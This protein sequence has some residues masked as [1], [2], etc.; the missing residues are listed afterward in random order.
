MN[1][2]LKATRP[3]SIDFSLLLLRL[4]AGLGMAFGHGLPKLQS[5][6]SKAD[7]FHNAFGL[8]SEL[9]LGLAIFAEFFCALLVSIGL[10]SRLAL[11]P[12]II[13][14]AVAV[15][16]VHWT[17]GF[18]KME[19]ALLYLIAYLAI[20]FGGAGKFSVDKVIKR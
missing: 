5:F 19:K 12:L 6:S 3:L 13:T 1:F 9:S 10:F 15:F 20:F 16:D 4:L 14:M 18:G 7:G 11:V 8:P 17:D 2:M